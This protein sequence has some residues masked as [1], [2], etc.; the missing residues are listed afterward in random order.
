MTPSSS[1]ALEQSTSGNSACIKSLV[2]SATEIPAASD[3]FDE[4]FNEASV[5]IIPSKPGLWLKRITNK[6]AR[7]LVDL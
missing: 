5:D 7:I 1:T 3:T 4:G 2:M 6:I